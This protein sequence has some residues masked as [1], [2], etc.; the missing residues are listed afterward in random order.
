MRKLEGKFNIISEIIPH[1]YYK[2]IQVNPLN[3]NQ[4]SN[5]PSI[6][7]VQFIHRFFDVYKNIYQTNIF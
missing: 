2:R 1:R 3:I 7:N 6:N 5:N 4:D